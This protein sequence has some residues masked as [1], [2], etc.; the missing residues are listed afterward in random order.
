MGVFDATYAPH[1]LMRGK[2]VQV[3]AFFEI[4]GSHGLI[5]VTRCSGE[6]LALPPVMVIKGT[7][8]T[9][10]QVPL[11]WRESF[12]GVARDCIDSLR[13]GRQPRQDARTA[14]KIVQIALTRYD[15]SELRRP[16]DPESIV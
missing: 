4:H 11:D 6:M 8:P 12:D 16:V 10:S 3:D 13:Q 9:S 1:M 14:K 7:K 15:A 2:Y 5:W